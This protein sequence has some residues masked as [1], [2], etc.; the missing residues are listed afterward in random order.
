MSDVFEEEERRMR[1]YSIIVVT[2]NNAEGLGR[3]LQSIRQLNYGQKETIV[4][5]GASN[6]S[7]MDV[8]AANKDLVTRF[9]S[10]KDTGIYNAMNKGE[11]VL[12]TATCFRW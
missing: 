5:D 7:T 1:T 11:I 8:L 6:D 9:V 3:T 2:R 4:I 12:Q 10:E